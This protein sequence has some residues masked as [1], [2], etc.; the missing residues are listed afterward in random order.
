MK[1]H[2]L[3]ALVVGLS[4]AMGAAEAAPKKQ[5]AKQVTGVINLN[6]ASASQ[7]DQLPG[8][9]PK[10]AE[11]IVAYRAKTPF[12]R[13]EDLIKVKGFGK[14]KLD[15]LKGHLAVS[16]PTTLRVMTGKEDPLASS[17]PAAQGRALAST[18]KR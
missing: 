15:K 8:V 6:T 14:K 5:S 4:M 9:G 1:R 7:L 17:E 16:G 12:G 18:P 13:P 3:A 10:A 2:T 11:R